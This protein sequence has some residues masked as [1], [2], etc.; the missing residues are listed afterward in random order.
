MAKTI[1]ELKWHWIKLDTADTWSVVLK[2]L[3]NRGINSEHLSRCVYS[4]RLA[5]KFGI[6]TGDA[7]TVESRR[8]SVTLPAQVVATIR[9]DTVFI[10]YHWANEKSANLLTIRA[11]DPV[12]K[13]PEF[14]VC[15]CRVEK[16]AEKPSSQS[17]VLSAQSEGGARLKRSEN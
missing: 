11:L 6:K 16:V 10:P 12:S 13:I 15:A 9:E 5:A 4:I 1:F 7:V 14:K 8:G 2:K 17:S 3:E